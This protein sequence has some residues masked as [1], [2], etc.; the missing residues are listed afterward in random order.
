MGSP[1]ERMPPDVA[2][3]VMGHL[4]WD[5]RASAAFRKTCKGWRDAHDQSVTCLRVT[6]DAL[7]SSAIERTI[8]PRVKE[9]GVRFHPGEHFEITFDDG[10]WLQTLA[11][12]TICLTSLDLGGC[13][14]SVR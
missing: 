6:G 14:Q 4:E 7:P 9:I 2:G 12:L 3:E 1:W 5:R 10:K 8:F 11:S 13:T